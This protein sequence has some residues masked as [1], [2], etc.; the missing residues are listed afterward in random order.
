MRRRARADSVNV[1]ATVVMEA[2]KLAPH[3]E[4]MRDALAAALGVEPAA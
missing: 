1:D 3:R 4:A 2:P